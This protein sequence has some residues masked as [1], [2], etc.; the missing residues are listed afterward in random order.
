[1]ENR[2]EHLSDEERDRIA[3]LKAEGTSVSQ[4]ARALGRDKSCISREL[5]RNRS[6]V[7][8]CY[9]A[10]AA[11][12]RAK[13]R[14]CK[15]GKRERLKRPE[16]RQYVVSKLQVGWSPELIAGR[17]GME[18]PG[19]GISHEAI[20]QYIYDPQVRKH[21]DLVPHLVRAHK[22]RLRR[23][24]SRKHR[25]SHIPDRVSIDERPSGVENRKQP[26]HWEADTIISR[27]S[28]VAL[29][30]FLERTSRYLHLAKLPQ[31]AAAPLRKALN[32]RL[33]RHPPHMRRTITY[34]NGSENVEHQKVN[35]VLGTQSY[36]CNP[37]CSWERGSVENTI[38]LV[39]RY[40]PKKTDFSEVSE[41]Q[42]KTIESLINSRPRKCLDF[43][44]P[45]EVF[46]RK[47]CT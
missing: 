42:L 5:R 35:K 34:D 23:G 17:I 27:Q 28:K 31:K 15:A 20:Y 39:R 4:I 3:V 43:K 47:C 29:G 46:N 22:K 7:Y 21:V 32:R 1:M 41:V 13:Q 24:H 25:K 11:G 12:K 8:K 44:T 16:I 37:Y 19:L 40:L 14:K 38:G 2:Y 45:A 10:T 26:G 9:H 18:Q 30:A 6:P 33:A 36:F